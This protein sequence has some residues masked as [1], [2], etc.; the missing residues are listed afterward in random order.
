MDS[1]TDCAS[2]IKYGIEKLFLSNDQAKVIFFHNEIN[3]I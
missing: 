3:K 1:L 2:K